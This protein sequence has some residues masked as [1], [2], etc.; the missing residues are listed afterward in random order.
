MT[1]GKRHA[2]TVTSASMPAVAA[3]RSQAS[4]VDL[5]K[6]R[7]ALMERNRRMMRRFHLH[8]LWLA[9]THAPYTPKRPALRR[10]VRRF[11]STR[12]GVRGSCCSRTEGRTTL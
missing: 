9:C 7:E 6:E 12:Q 3:S 11:G 10:D 1:R 2:V 8:L 4:H 5:D